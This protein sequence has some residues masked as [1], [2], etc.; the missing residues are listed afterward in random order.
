MKTVLV[1]DDSFFMRNMLKK[2][3]HEHSYSVIAEAE[4]GLDAI[5]KYEKYRPD[6]VLLDLTMP[7]LGGFD[8]LKEIK[9][10]DPKANV[11]ICSSM[12]TKFNFI[13]ALRLGARDFV[14][15]PNFDNLP[16]ILERIFHS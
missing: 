13:E 5:K 11:I 6:V 3:L 15:K 16:S 14:M 7:V 12:G 9:R 8:A 1:V 10:I 2:I 4:N